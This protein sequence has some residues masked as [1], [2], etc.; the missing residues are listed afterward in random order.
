MVSNLCKVCRKVSFVPAIIVSSSASVC[1]A[2]LEEADTCCGGSSGASALSLSFN[3]S[4]AH[5]D[6]HSEGW[7]G[8]LSNT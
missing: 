1:V 3:C 8:R 4:S 2:E 5:C 6:F 7:W